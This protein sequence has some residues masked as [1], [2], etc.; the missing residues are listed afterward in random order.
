MLAGQ[1]DAR[2]ATALSGAL[3]QLLSSIGTVQTLDRA[4]LARFKSH[5]QTF[6]TD[7]K[8]IVRRK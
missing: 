3:Q 5:L 6:V 2:L 1:Q 4:S 8:S 7:A